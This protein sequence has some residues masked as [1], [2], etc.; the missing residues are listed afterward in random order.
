[1]RKEKT[2]SLASERP[3]ADGLIEGIN[4]NPINTWGWGM[5]GAWGRGKQSIK[6][7]LESSTGRKGILGEVIPLGKCLQ[8]R[9]FA[10]S[11]CLLC[12]QHYCRMKGMK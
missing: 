5:K 3:R 2:L 9:K 7:G 10:L 1:M 8:V 4:M 6:E 11:W 12:A